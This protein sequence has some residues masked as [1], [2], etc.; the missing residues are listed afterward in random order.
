MNFDYMPELHWIAGYP[1]ALA[2]MVLVAVALYLMFRRR[3][4]L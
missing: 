2:L 3:G 1:A 4:W